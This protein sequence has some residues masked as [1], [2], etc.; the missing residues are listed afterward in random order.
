MGINMQHEG[1]GFYLCQ[2]IEKYVRFVA[3]RP[4]AATLCF[5][6][7]LN[8]DNILF[9]LTFK[10]EIGS[11]KCPACGCILYI[12]DKWLPHK[13]QIL[14]W[15]LVIINGPVDKKYRFLQYPGSAWCDKILNQSIEL[16]HTNVSLH[17]MIISNPSWIQFNWRYFWDYVHNR[18]DHNYRNKY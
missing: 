11:R 17:G 2:N 6:K 8:H 12:L 15:I 18:F 1:S 16:I 5:L 7:L 3:A 14:T 10:T 4:S 13:P 9:I